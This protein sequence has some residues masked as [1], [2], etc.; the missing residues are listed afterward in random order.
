M[1]ERDE[2]MKAG[3]LTFFCFGLTA[4]LKLTLD[5]YSSALSRDAY[6]TIT[7][8]AWTVLLCG[9]LCGAIALNEYF[10][11]SIRLREPRGEERSSHRAEVKILA[12]IFGLAVAGILMAVTETAARLAIRHGGPPTPFM[13]GARKATVILFVVGCVGS[14]AVLR[15]LGKDLLRP[16]AKSKRYSGVAA[17]LLALFGV[18]AVVASSLPEAPANSVGE[19]LSSLVSFLQLVFGTTGLIFSALAVWHQRKEREARRMAARESD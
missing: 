10:T 12:W 5:V 9:V 6:F 14:P 3:A 13:Q 16:P 11:T 17:M 18:S 1:L 4:T 2:I 19:A 15:L 7:V 8:S